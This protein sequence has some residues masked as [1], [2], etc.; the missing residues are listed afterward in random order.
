MA[1][2]IVADDDKVTRVMIRAVLEADGHDLL[3]AQNGLECLRLLQTCSPDIIIM[4]VFMPQMSG[5]EAV[6]AIRAKDKNI[7]IIG[8]SGGGE[9][10]KTPYLNAILDS[11]ANMVVAKPIP[12]D[13]L[14]KLIAEVLDPPKD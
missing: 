10:G 13:Q 9:H 3:E 4:D 7:K 12:S 6:A 11:G 1:Q 2:I 5:L 14:K 8:M